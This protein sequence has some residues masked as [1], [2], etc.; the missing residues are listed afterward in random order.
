M[1]KIR[2]TSEVCE[3]MIAFACACNSAAY[4]TCSNA[5]VKDCMFEN[6]INYPTG[7][8]TSTNSSTY[9]SLASSNVSWGK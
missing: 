1:K 5:C 3:S 6:N 8:T 2:K 7:Y 4:D 9:A